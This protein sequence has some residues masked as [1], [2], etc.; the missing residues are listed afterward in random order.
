M[1]PLSGILVE[2]LVIG[3]ISSIWLLPAAVNSSFFSHLV[4]KEFFGVAIA[5]LV[6]T[7]FMVGML[8][9]SV[10]YHATHWLKKEFEKCK[11]VCVRI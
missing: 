5:V 9:D 6:P 2:Y 4:N 1:K 3:S 8:H 7:I 11:A 10:G